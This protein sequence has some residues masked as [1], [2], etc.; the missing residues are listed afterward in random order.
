VELR[1]SQFRLPAI[2]AGKHKVRVLQ[3]VQ[4]V[5]KAASNMATVEVRDERAGATKADGG[6][7]TTTGAETKAAQVEKL[8]RAIKS[9]T[10]VEKQAALNQFGEERIV[11][12]IPDAIEAIT[13]ITELPRD[14]D[15]GWGFVGHQASSLLRAQIAPAAFGQ[16]LWGEQHK[17]SFHDDMFK[18]GKALRDSG[19]LKEVQDNW[20]AWW[21]VNKGKALATQAGA[22]VVWGEAVEG[23]RLGIRVPKTLYAIGEKL[24]P[25]LWASNVSDKSLTW[26]Y[27]EN[28]GGGIDLTGV[29]TDPKDNKAGEIGFQF[30]EVMSDLMWPRTT[31]LEPGQEAKVVDLEARILHMPPTG[32][33]DVPGALLTPPGK[34]SVGADVPP[35]PYNRTA[36]HWKTGKVVIEVAARTR[37]AAAGD[38]PKGGTPNGARA[39]DVAALVTALKPGAGW[40]M[41]RREGVV[42]PINLEPGRGVELAFP[43]VKPESIKTIPL[44]L[45]IMDGDYK[46]GPAPPPR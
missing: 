36:G 42:Q 8:R 3:V 14:G 37:G 20:R 12:L 33:Q 9:G 31:A 30:G 38:P 23:V 22:E 35:Y 40:T 39:S 44:M 16:D 28:P 45:W 19:R 24:T 7:G 1:F 43:Q 18:G 2:T 25:E 32:S 5:T 46:G 6:V 27:W 21:A 10:P 41:V 15:T 11:A 29:V 17:Y 13:D 26:T 4:G 34:Y